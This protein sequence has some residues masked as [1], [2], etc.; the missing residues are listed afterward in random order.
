MWWKRTVDEACRRALDVVAATL[1]LILLSP[2]FALIALIINLDTP[3]PV[4]FRG[5]RVGKHERR[6][7]LYK[8]RTMIA[9]A[10]RRGPGITAANDPRATRV[11]RFLRHTKLDELPQ[12]LNVL[13]GDMS[14]VGPRPE[15]PRYV[16]LYSPEQRRVLSVRPGITSPASVR[17]RHEEEAL[18]GE[19][20][21]RA[22]R[23]EVIPAKLRIELGYLEHRSVWRDL[24]VIVQT[25]LALV[26]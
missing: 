20:W 23:E 25:A 9:D 18:Q 4:F 19:D 15:D 2:C 3:G 5:E 10:D 11:G 21:E 7:H 13:C 1:G 12:L 16:A 14:L 17:F 24:V 26:R 6:F 22:Y 8:F